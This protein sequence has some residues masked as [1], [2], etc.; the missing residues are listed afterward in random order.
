MLFDAFNGL[1]Q[2]I[3]KNVNPRLL[4][5]FVFLLIAVSIWYLNALNKDYTTELNF[6]VRY[7]DLPDDKA[8]ANTPPE[9]LTL[10]VHAQGFTLLKYKYRLGLIL[11]PITLEASY[12]TLRRSAA[13]GVYYLVT[14]SAFDKVSVQLGSD[15]QL[16]Q[17]APDT[18]K[19]LFS[20]TIRKNIPVKP[21]V[22]LQYEKGF[23]PR[24]AIV[25][26]PAKVTVTGPKAL[27]D[28]MQFVYSRTKVFKKQKE[29][30]RTSIELQPVHQLRYSVN[31]AVIEQVVERNTEATVVAPIEPVNLP[32]NLTM[33]LFPGTVTINCM[34]PVAD[35][36]KLQ[37]YM[38]RAVV[39]YTGIRDDQTK[40]RVTLLRTPDD[41]TEV[42]FQPKTV[43][44]IIEK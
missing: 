4:T 6:K 43:D 32:G 17:I 9:Q 19:F 41:V 26:E 8:L 30:L 28:T 15:V 14:Q 7:T 31:E 42:R 16:R 11:H 38:F 24:G 27:V 36:E 18:L 37:P 20:E 23:L 1:V 33:K 21:A 13:T 5:Y 39:D 22:Q 35:Y 10:T 29:T 25:V 3:K 34:V 12:Q 44:F 2:K 40:A